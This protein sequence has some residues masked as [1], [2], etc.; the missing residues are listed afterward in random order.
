ME[1]EGLRPTICRFDPT[2]LASTSS[3]TR[4]SRMGLL[5]HSNR[6]ESPT[7]EMLGVEGSAGITQSGS[8]GGRSYWL[9]VM[10]EAAAARAQ[11]QQRWC[12][13]RLG[14]HA[15]AMTWHDIPRTASS[16]FTHHCCW[17][18]IQDGGLEFA[19]HSPIVTSTVASAVLPDLSTTVYLQCEEKRNTL[20]QC[21]VAARCLCS[22]R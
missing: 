1:A 17:V 4:W 6:K 5:G 20:G 11:H 13:G 18:H 21:H 7:G 2:S 8:T 12:T 19:T 14:V 22:K 3:L 16:V 15:A 9:R 10:L